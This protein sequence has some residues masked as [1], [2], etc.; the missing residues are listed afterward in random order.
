M[1]AQGWLPIKDGW[2]V[3]LEAVMRR[4]KYLTAVYRGQVGEAV[5]FVL[6]KIDNASKTEG[7]GGY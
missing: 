4:K 6:F 1:V 7:G 5:M 3:N 2:D